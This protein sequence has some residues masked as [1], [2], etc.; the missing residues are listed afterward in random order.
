MNLPDCTSP[1]RRARPSAD[2]QPGRKRSPRREKKKPCLMRC[3]PSSVPRR[4]GHTAA[5]RKPFVLA[6]LCR[7]A[8]PV[9]ESGLPAIQAA[10][11]GPSSLLGLT[12]GGVYHARRLTTPAVRSYRTF[13]PLPRPF[14][15]PRRYIFCG[16]FPVQT[17][18][19]I[20]RAQTVGVTHHRDPAVLGL[21]SPAPGR[22]G[23][24]RIRL[25]HYNRSDA[26]IN[27]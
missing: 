6:R 11:I 24:P 10:W 12:P 7:R 21:S 15:R 19:R 18:R 26:K 23:L 14:D 1:C 5:G 4:G 3:K 22:S 27:S 25:P 9:R 20:A 16:T 13:S 2:T 8:L 17:R